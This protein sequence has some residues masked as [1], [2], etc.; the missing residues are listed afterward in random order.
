MI[1]NLSLVSSDFRGEFIKVFDELLAIYPHERGNFGYQSRLMRRE[2]RRRH[3]AIPLLHRNGKA[4][5]IS[6]KN[7]RMRQVA[8]ERLPK[9]GVYKIA[10]EMRFSDE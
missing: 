3:Q 6:P 10:A 2:Y 1:S 7:G 8:I 4:Y 9:F 5:K